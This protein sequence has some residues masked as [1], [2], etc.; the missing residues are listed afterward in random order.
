MCVIILLFF[1]LLYRITSS[2]AFF[3]YTVCYATATRT[4]PTRR[5]LHTRQ[6]KLT[7]R[8][9]FA[10][11]WKIMI[12][13]FFFNF[14]LFRF[15]DVWEFDM[16]AKREKKTDTILNQSCIK[17]NISILANAFVALCNQFCDWDFILTFLLNYFFHSLLINSN[18]LSHTLSWQ[19]LQE[20]NKSHRH[21]MM[22][23]DDGA[24][25]VV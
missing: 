12:K 2:R 3:S 15:C 6:N 22:T 21:P 18:V 19:T 8:P 17:L 20:G 11:S 14:I 23:Y 9:E 4:S 16:D 7:A 25:G 1:S 5:T 24:E 10:C 13:S